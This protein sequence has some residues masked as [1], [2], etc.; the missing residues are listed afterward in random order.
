MGEQ[1]RVVAFVDQ[2]L[3]AISTVKANADKKLLSGKRIFESYREGTPSSR[4][5]DWLEAPLG[6]IRDI[7]HGH[8]FEGD[9]FALKEMM[10]CSRRECL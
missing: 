1:K 2:E 7:R 4:I 6:T 3:E 5:D 9:F 10:R 8:A